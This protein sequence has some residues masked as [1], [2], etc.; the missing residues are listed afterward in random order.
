MQRTNVP[1]PDKHDTATA[2]VPF[3]ELCEAREKATALLHKPEIETDALREVT[4][5]DYPVFPP[6][7]YFITLK[8]ITYV[9]YNAQ[10]QQSEPN[11]PDPE[12][13]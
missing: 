4:N 1:H 9:S 6:M 7:V 2:K 8:I 5:T 11:S 10:V 3:Q 12:P 13:Y